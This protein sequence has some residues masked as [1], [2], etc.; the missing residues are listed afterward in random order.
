MPEPMVRAMGVRLAEALAAM[1]ALRQVFGDLRRETV[2]MDADGARLGRAHLPAGREVSPADD[3]YALGGVLVF[4]ATGRTPFLENGL[5]ALP[6]GLRTVLRDCLSDDPSRRPRAGEL[7][8]ALADAPEQTTRLSPSFAG[9]TQATQRFLPD[10]ATVP[11]PPQFGAAQQHSRTRMPWIIAAVCGL[12]VVIIL[13]TVG[14]VAATRD[15]GAQTAGDTSTS[16]SGKADPA[17]KYTAASLGDACALLDLPAAEKVIGKQSGTPLGDRIELPSIADTLSCNTM[18]DHGFIMLH[19]ELSDQMSTVRQLYDLHRAT[20]L[21][22]TGSGVTAKTVSGIG[23]DAYLV[24][25]EPNSGNTQQIGCQLG[26]LQ[27][28]VIAIVNLHLSEDDGSTRDK[29]AEYCQHQARTV[30]GRLK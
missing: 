28:N 27:S 25:H 5:D 6:P 14:V 22:T 17:T 23:E 20:G 2:L 18:N 9:D 24:V 13:A 30:L 10:A 19:I 4:A 7:A 16:P 8:R 29:L 11:V 1:H 12:L 26:F 3:V 15:D 21:G